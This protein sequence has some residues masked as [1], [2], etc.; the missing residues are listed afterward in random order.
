M[1]TKNIFINLL[2]VSILLCLPQSIQAQI[3]ALDPYPITIQAAGGVTQELTI[4]SGC[5]TSNFD[6]EIISGSDFASIAELDASTGK[7]RLELTPNTSFSMRSV[8]LRISDG[9]SQSNIVDIQQY[10]ATITL[11]CSNITGLPASIEENVF[12]S[13]PATLPYQN[14]TGGALILSDGDILGGPVNGLTVKVNGNQSLTDSSGNINILVEGTPANA[15]NTSIPV[16][17]GRSR[18]FISLI[19]DKKTPCIPPTVSVVSNPLPSNISVGNSVTLTATTTGSAPLTYVWSKS[20]TVI[21][22]ATGA[23][24]NVGTMSAS[25]FVNYSVTVS[26][27]CGSATAVWSPCGAYTTGGEWL[28]FM[29]HNLGADYKKNPFQWSSA[30]ATGGGIFQWGRKADG[31]ESRS[32]AKTSGY[33]TSLDEEGQPT[34]NMKGKFIYR[35]PTLGAGS[36]WRS[37]QDD[38]LWSDDTKGKG[39]PCPTGWKV[40]SQEQWQQVLDNNKWTVVNSGSKYYGLKVGNALFLPATGSRWGYNGNLTSA[41]NDKISYAYYWSSTATRV[42]DGVNLNYSAYTLKIRLDNYYKKVTT[43]YL[44]GIYRRVGFAVRCVAE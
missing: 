34:G 26:N 17:L 19:V 3:I 1:K 25:D 14:R 40:P 32:S 29:C 33:A 12:V 15:E 18:C 30:Q 24:Y 43:A 38:A 8:Q 37:T 10:Q 36:D 28:P 13:I 35:S 4:I 16:V 11:L 5:N 41:D 2:L 22:G 27:E 39:D 23:T 20:G 21:P 9:C 6:V 31:H 44:D 7:F 42:H